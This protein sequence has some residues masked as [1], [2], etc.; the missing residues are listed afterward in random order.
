MHHFNV[1]TKSLPGEIPAHNK[2][3]A[4]ISFQNGPRHEAGRNG[5]STEAVLTCIELY[6]EH[7]TKEFPSREG[8]LCLTKVQE[9][10]LWAAERAR[11]RARRGVLGKSKA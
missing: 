2:L 3:V 6:L 9:A 4:S 11:S 7:V 5:I 1:W 10:R 8:A